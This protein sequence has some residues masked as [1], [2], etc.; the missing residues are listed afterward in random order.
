MST[1]LRMSAAYSGYCTGSAPTLLYADVPTPGTALGAQTSFTCNVGD[2][3]NT[4]PT[5]P[6]YTCTPG[7]PSPGVWSSVTGACTREHRSRSFLSYLDL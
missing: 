6:F 5:A 7:S 3:S 1:V 4:A 2:V